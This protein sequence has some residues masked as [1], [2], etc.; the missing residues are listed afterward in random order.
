MKRRKKLAVSCA[1]VLVPFSASAQQPVEQSSGLTVLTPVETA[2]AS[3]GTIRIPV[4]TSVRIETVSPLG[5]KLSKTGDSFSISLWEPLR[6]DGVEV[7]PRGTPGT[8]EVVH[9]ARA[10][11][12]GKAGELIVAARFLEGSGQRIKLRSFQIIA[13]DQTGES[14]AGTA[15]L[16]GLVSAPLALFV[17]GGEINIPAG[18]VASAKV[19][20]DVEVQRTSTAASN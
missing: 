18:T 10:R 7:L 11:A 1:L 15:M 13:Q 6:I 2:T 8:G 19:A 12:A 3:E 20:A 9:A 5:S 17:V 4:G 14:S 16:V